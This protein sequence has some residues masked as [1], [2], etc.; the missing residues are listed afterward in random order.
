MGS[1][2]NF[3]HLTLQ[4]VEISTVAAHLTVLDSAVATMFSNTA[5]ASIF[6]KPPKD[7]HEMPTSQTWLGR[8]HAHFGRRPQMCLHACTSAHLSRHSLADES[9]TSCVLPSKVQADIVDLGVNVAQF[10]FC[11]GSGVTSS[12]SGVLVWC[13]CI[14]PPCEVL[15]DAASVRLWHLKDGGS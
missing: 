2:L 15:H 7:A 8:R 9:C 14:L 11:R 1:S 13:H 12:V 4:L 6:L 5:M 3:S 10:Y